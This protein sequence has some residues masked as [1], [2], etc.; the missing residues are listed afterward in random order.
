MDKTLFF[1]I[2]VLFNKIITKKKD[3]IKLK[4]KKY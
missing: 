2:N 4:T 3:S 1:G